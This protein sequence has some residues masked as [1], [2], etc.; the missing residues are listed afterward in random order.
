MG[1]CSRPG[2]IRSR[3]EFI[4]H[5]VSLLS[6]DGTTKISNICHQEH[7]RADGILTV[8]GPIK[9]NGAKY[10]RKW[11]SHLGIQDKKLNFRRISPAKS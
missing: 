11:A 4:I 10:Q 8:R 2:A 1:D 5:N 9:K 3:I 6:S 7:L